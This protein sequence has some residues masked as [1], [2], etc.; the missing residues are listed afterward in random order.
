[1]G[2][3][4]ADQRHQR[5]V[6]DGFRCPRTDRLVDEGDSSAEVRSKCGAPTSQETFPGRCRQFDERWI[7]DFGPAYLTRILL[8]KCGRLVRVELGGYGQGGDG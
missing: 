4:Q 2:R 8:F 7:Y 5:P 3:A 6:A 1:M